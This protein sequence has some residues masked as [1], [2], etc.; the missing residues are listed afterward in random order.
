MFPCLKMNVLH[1][2]KNKDLLELA[3]FLSGS[4]TSIY[5][6]EFLKITRHKSISGFI[7]HY[8]VNLFSSNNMNL[9]KSSIS[10]ADLDS[11]WLDKSFSNKFQ[12]SLDKRWWWLS[13]IEI[14]WELSLVH[15]NCSRVLLCISNINPK[16]V[17]KDN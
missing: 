12:T 6:S 5:K 1:S 9:L 16:Q 14:Y 8:T 11:I 3:L 13:R 15:I 4:Y 10:Q 2:I 17:D 7:S